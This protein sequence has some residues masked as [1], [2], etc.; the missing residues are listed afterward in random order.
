VFQVVLH[1]GFMEEPNVPRGLTQGRASKLGVDPMLTSS[2]LGSESLVVTKR[3]GMAVWR[4]HVFAFM[5][6]NATSAANYFGLPPDQT[7]TVG[8]QVEI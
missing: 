5:S 4:E 2:F 7:T 6:R 1:F 8:M 3:P